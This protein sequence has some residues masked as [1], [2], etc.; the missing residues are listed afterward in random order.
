MATGNQ[1]RPQY[2]PRPQSS[3]GYCG[4]EAERD[5]LGPLGPRTNLE[6]GELNVKHPT[7]PGGAS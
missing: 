7:D 2:P 6:V 1:P 5:T 4:P 3:L